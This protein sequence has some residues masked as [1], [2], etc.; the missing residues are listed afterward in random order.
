M[1]V[2]ERDVVWRT[3]KG[4]TESEHAKF[5]TAACMSIEG[6]VRVEEGRQGGVL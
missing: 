6:V 1:A 5:L 3:R 4:F 2:Y